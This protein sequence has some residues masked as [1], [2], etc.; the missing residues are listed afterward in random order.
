MA[1]RRFDSEAT[2]EGEDLGARRLRLH[3]LLVGEAAQW[4]ELATLEATWS[5]P[6]RLLEALLGSSSRRGAALRESLAGPEIGEVG[7]GAAVERGG[8]ALCVVMMSRWATLD[9]VSPAP[10]HDGVTFRGELGPGVAAEDLTARFRVDGGP[11]STDA[12]AAV[13]DIGHLE[14]GVAGRFRLLLP[15]PPE[16]HGESTEVQFS[17]GGV[18]GRVRQL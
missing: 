13:E 9:D 18:S 5:D 16:A 6:S 1:T 15:V 2:P 7:V 4:Q 12:R 11:W 14:G 3:P 8:V 17:R 10:G